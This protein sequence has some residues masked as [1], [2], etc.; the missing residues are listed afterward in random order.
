MSTLYSDSVVECT[1]LFNV[2]YGHVHYSSVDTTKILP[3]DL[4]TYS[5]DP[6]YLLEGVEYRICMKNGSWSEEQPVC[7]GE[8]ANIST[9]PYVF[10]V[11][12]YT[13]EKL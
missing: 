6:P 1:P 4:V 5:C 11:N 3:G 9:E 2:P 7:I 10:S 13:A 8:I 12:T